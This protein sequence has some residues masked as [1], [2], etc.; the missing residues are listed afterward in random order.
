MVSGGSGSYLKSFLEAL[1]FILTDYEPVSSH[2]ESIRVDFDLQGGNYV[3][4]NIQK[5]KQ[6]MDTSFIQWSRR[7]RSQT[8]IT[9]EQQEQLDLPVWATIDKQFGTCVSKLKTMTKCWNLLL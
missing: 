4:P 3:T 5:T 6:K 8:P 2:G 1:R 7:N 9:R